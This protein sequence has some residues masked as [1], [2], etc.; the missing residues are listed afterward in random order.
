MEGVVGKGWYKLII[1]VLAGLLPFG[2][3][4]GYDSINAVSIYLENDGFSRTQIGALYSAYSFPNLIMVFIGGFLIDKIGTNRTTLIFSF[5]IVIGAFVVALTSS[6][7]VMILGRLI[8][9]MGSESTIVAQSTILSNWFAP[10]DD[11]DS[12]NAFGSGSASASESTSLLE[13]NEQQQQQHKDNK[14]GAKQNNNNNQMA[15]AFGGALTLARAGSFSAF[16]FLSAVA[17]WT[18]GYRWPLWIVLFVCIVCFALN[19]GLNFLNVHG[20]VPQKLSTVVLIEDQMSHHQ[21]HSRGLFSSLMR[22]PKELWNDLKPILHFPLSFWLIGA[23]CF[24]TY[25]VVF[26]FI[27]FSSDYLHYEWGYTDSEASRIASIMTL[28]SMIFSPIFGFVI[29]KIGKRVTIM[30]VGQVLLIPCM[31]AMAWAGTSDASSDHQDLWNPNISADGWLRGISPYPWIVMIGFAYSLAP[32]AMWPCIPLIVDKKHVGVAFG[33]LTVCQNSSGV[34]VPAILGLVRD[35]TG[36]YLVG[37]FILAALAACGALFCLALRWVIW[38]Q[39][40]YLETPS[41]RKPEF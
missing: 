27:T 32:A 41:G 21:H 36:N 34:I 38:R 12:N 25:G 39:G 22:W 16:I 18:N 6:F 7:Y 29:D 40:D 14:S 33:M 19:F 1:F 31:I 9:G 17:D 30:I 35:V 20:G 4:F 15:L 24:A 10:D 5:L 11:L 8:F 23:V 28:S 37:H 13:L 3:Y 2:A 26:T